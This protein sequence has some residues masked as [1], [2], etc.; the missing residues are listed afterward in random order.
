MGFPW[1][2]VSAPTL[3]TPGGLAV[4]LN[5]SGLNRSLPRE[6]ERGGEIE[7]GNEGTS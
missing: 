3:W 2:S 4:G 1:A 7:E 6:R 5:R